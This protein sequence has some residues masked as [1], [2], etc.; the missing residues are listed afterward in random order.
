MA[1]HYFR[2]GSGKLNL[3]LDKNQLNS[4]LEILDFQE[5]YQ[6]REEAREEQRRREE[7]RRDEQRRKEAEVGGGEVGDWK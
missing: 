6:R 1:V 5:S 4:V 3:K 2:L 7:E